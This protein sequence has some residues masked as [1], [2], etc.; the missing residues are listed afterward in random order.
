MAPIVS[1]GIST[2]LQQLM[3]LLPKKNMP[4]EQEVQHSVQKWSKLWSLQVGWENFT[5]ELLLECS[6]ANPKPISTFAIVLTNGDKFIQVAHGFGLLTMDSD[7]NPSNRMIGCSLGDQV[8]TEFQGKTSHCPGTHVHD[9]TEECTQRLM[10]L[11]AV[12]GLDSIMMKCK[13]LC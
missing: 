4:P 6:K 5:Q 9:I 11:L 8:V 10:T 13:K 12:L 1:G 7:D 3:Q 2:L